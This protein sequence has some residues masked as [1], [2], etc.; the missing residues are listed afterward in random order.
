MYQSVWLNSANEYTKPNNQKFKS[1]QSLDKNKNLSQ[2]YMNH[3]SK[4]TTE[5]PRIHKRVPCLQ[6][7][8]CS[9]FENGSLICQHDFYPVRLQHISIYHHGFPW[10]EDEK[11]DDEYKNR[12][13]P[14]SN[15]TRST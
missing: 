12:K 9:Y 11:K 10:L 7:K 15:K 3:D 8:C 1:K 4:L 14:R 13:K 2:N 5:F 6:L